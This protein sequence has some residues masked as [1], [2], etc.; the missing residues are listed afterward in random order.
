MPEMESLQGEGSVFYSCL[1]K[2][3][4]NGPPE[5]TKDF[6]QAAAN[7]AMHCQPELCTQSF[8]PLQHFLLVQN[9]SSKPIAPTDNMRPKSGDT[10]RLHWLLKGY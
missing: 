4:D 5:L 9:Q 1:C 3:A 10:K 8:S 2:K 6:L 7:T